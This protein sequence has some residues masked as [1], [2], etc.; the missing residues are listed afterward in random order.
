MRLPVSKLPITNPKPGKWYLAVNCDNCNSRLILLEDLSNGTSEI[1]GTYILTS[2]NV[3]TR[4]STKSNATI[5]RKRG[6]FK[7]SRYCALLISLSRLS[8][9]TCRLVFAT[10]RTVVVQT[11]SPPIRRYDFEFI[12]KPDF[13]G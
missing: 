11:C 1:K 4:R 10:S 3:T 5:T 6:D 7:L 2:L 9:S 13:Y 8:C 12:A